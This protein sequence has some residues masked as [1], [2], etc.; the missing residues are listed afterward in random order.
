MSQDW[1]CTVKWIQATPTDGAWL[2]KIFLIIEAKGEPE[3]VK[4]EEGTAFNKLSV[5][6]KAWRACRKHGLR[7]RP[8]V[9]G[10]IES[11]D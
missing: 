10:K 6:W 7:F 11:G 3:L 1:I 8:N 2:W 9:R 4:V 5:Y